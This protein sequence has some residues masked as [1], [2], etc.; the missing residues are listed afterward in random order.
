MDIQNFIQNMPKAELHVHLEG[1]LEPEL[2]RRLAERNKISLPEALTALEQKDGYSF[3]DLTS[4]LD[5]YYGA[6]SV[7]QTEDD[8][9]DLTYSY[10]LKCKK[11]NIVMT[12]MF[13]DPQAHTG[14]GVPFPVVIN[15]IQRAMSKAKKQLSVRASLIMCFLRDQSP[16]FAMATLMDALPYKKWITGVGLDSDERGNPPIKFAGVFKRATEEGFMTTAHCD[17]DQDNS[18]EHIRQVLK[19]LEIDRIDHGVN[20]LE[21]EKLVQMVKDQGIG[22]TCCPVSNSI[23]TPDFKGKEIKQLLDRG[24]RVTVNSDD[25]AYFRSYLNENMLKMWDDGNGLTKE[26]LLQ[27]QLNAFEI[28]WS[29]ISE[30]Q[31]WHGALEDYRWQTIG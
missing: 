15:G 8:F 9:Y 2:V 6:M 7:L 25:P 23:V 18:I 31:R 5:V 27:L 22:L 4:F 14:R 28:S 13:F 17:V 20:I 29:P 19:E 12:E 1:T 10:L 21:D 30:V 11:Q 24:I 16:A 26:E 3:S